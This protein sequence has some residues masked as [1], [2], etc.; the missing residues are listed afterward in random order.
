MKKKYEYISIAGK[1]IKAFLESIPIEKIDFVEFNP[2]ISMIRDSYALE[3]LE[4]TQDLI[5]HGLIT[6]RSFLNLRDN[7]KKHNGALVPIWIYPKNNKYLVIEGN[8]RLLVYKILKEENP[9]DKNYN[10]INCLILP[11]EIE[12]EDKNFIRLTSHL[13]GYTDWDKYERSKYLYVLYY[14]QKYP[15]VKLA[16]ITKLST[17]DIKEDIEAYEIM[18]KQF[19]NKYA[20]ADYVGKW[21]YFKE[22]VKNNKLRIT[23]EDHKFTSKDFA[24]WIYNNKF[25]RARDIRKLQQILANKESREMFIK[26]DFDRALEILKEVVPEKSEKIYIIIKDLTNRFD[27]MEYAEL[28]SMFRDHNSPKRR[29]FLNLLEKMKNMLKKFS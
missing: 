28:D 4:M 21:S 1:K 10:N 19:I 23:M 13:H 24:D 8:S 14:N 7:I 25:E 11:K 6:Q 15:I 29:I 3:G 18:T 16:K 26:K 5:Q 12:E 22:F 27:K 17:R 20:D 2:R 9:S